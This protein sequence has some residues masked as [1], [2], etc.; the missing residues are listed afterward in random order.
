M[1][2]HL[3]Q[4]YCK[5]L[6]IGILVVGLLIETQ[7][8]YAAVTGPSN[9]AWKLQ[10]GDCLSTNTCACVAAG[11]HPLQIIPPNGVVASGPGQASNGTLIPQCTKLTSTT[12]QDAVAFFQYT[13]EWNLNVP[14]TL[15]ASADSLAAAGIAAAD[16][17]KYVA[18]NV[19][20]RQCTPACGGGT[21]D[22]ALITTGTDNWICQQTDLSLLN[23]KTGQPVVTTVSQ[24]LCIKAGL[25]PNPT[26]TFTNN[27]S[28]DTGTWTPGQCSETCGGGTILPPTCSAGVGQCDSSTE[29][30][31]GQSCNAQ[32][33]ATAQCGGAT[34]TQSG[35]LD[36]DYGAYGGTGTLQSPSPATSTL[37]ASGSTPTT[38]T[39]SNGIWSWSCSA[40]NGSSSNVS[41]FTQPICLSNNDTVTDTMT[42]YQAGT[43][44]GSVGFQFT[45]CCGS[46]CT[47]S[48][49]PVVGF[50][51]GGITG[52]SGATGPDPCPHS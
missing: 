12:G 15:F 2:V 33:C 34:S 35:T 21:C 48:Q 41:C 10:A 19:N 5:A 27:A 17:D 39:I 16:C 23:P 52:C 38:P 31:Y 14:A 42:T 6:A 7:A 51:Q 49:G 11:P 40:G 9:C 13:G 37:C 32:A 44:V 36:F 1:S 47:T 45:S 24:S 22:G 46:V 26:Y 3:R 4:S 28:C 8:A 29:P 20:Y 50:G 18:T 25:A 30:P 43:G